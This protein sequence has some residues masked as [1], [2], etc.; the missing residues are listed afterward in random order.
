M[1]LAH[2]CVNLIV[3]IQN[4]VKI[5]KIRENIIRKIRTFLS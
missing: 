3:F 5:D 1:F 4:I 2:F